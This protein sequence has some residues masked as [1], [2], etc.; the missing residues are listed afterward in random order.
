VIHVGGLEGSA[1][2]RYG[3]DPVFGSDGH[4]ASPRPFLNAGL[5]KCGLDQKQ[6]I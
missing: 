3:R 2:A 5:Q 4:A 6:Y 1:Q